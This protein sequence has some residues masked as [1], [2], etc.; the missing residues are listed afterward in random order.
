MKT[1]IL[2]I[3]IDGL[4][5]N[6]AIESGSAPTLAALKEE[7]F[8]RDWPDTY[9]EAWAQPKLRTRKSKLALLDSAKAVVFC[10]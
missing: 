8:A 7:G 10:T 2:L 6:L 4:L 9:K 1:K 3:G 5:L